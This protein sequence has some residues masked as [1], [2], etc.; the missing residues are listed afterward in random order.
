MSLSLHH[1]ESIQ[2]SHLYKLLSL[3]FRYPTQEIFQTF[4]NGE[5]LAGLWDSISLLPHIKFLKA[6]QAE[7]GK[8]AQNSL[9]KITFEDFAAIGIS[10]FDAG[11]PEPPCPPYEGFYLNRSRTSIMLD[12]TEFYRYFGLAM[13]RRDGKRELPDHLCAELEFLHF[14]VFKESQAR[15][16]EDAEFLGGYLLAQKDFLRRHPAQ[17]VP[18]F[19]DLLCSRADIPFY[20]LLARIA[21]TFITHELELVT[22]RVTFFKERET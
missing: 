19:C 7:Q 22:S 6:E 13:S 8:Q 21:V 18:K 12:I 9:K 1:T 16:D 5:F 11:I 3:G 20:H 15:I 4:Q 10:A 14:L 17:W 2:R